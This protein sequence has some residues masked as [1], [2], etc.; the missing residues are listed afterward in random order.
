V[1]EELLK[2]VASQGR[3]CPAPQRW[4]DLWELLP[5][6]KRVGGGWDPPLP[7]ILAPSLTNPALPVKMRLQEH[8][9]Y[10]DTHGVLTNV[11]AF[12]RS[13]PEDQ[14]LHVGDF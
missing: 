11:D 7:L 13:L 5:N 8:I 10:A 1:L 14:W 4:N 6:R 3:V 2:Y 12:L 9:R